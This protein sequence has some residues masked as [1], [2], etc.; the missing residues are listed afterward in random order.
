M[1]RSEMWAFAKPLYSSPGNK[2]STLLEIKVKYSHSN[3]LLTG[4]VLCFYLALHHLTNV[5]HEF[6]VAHM[7]DMA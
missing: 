2:T 3:I 6:T 5:W 7:N 4:S 1:K